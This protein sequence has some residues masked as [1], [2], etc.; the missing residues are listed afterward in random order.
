[1]RKLFVII[2]LA[3]MLFTSHKAYALFDDAYGRNYPS[4]SSHYSSYSPLDLSYEFRDGLSVELLGC[5]VND[6]DG[7]VYNLFLAKS[8]KDMKLDVAASAL[9]DNK[10]GRFTL[11]AVTGGNNWGIRMAGYRT[12]NLTLIADVPIIIL[13][14]YSAEYEESSRKPENLRTASTM[15]YLFNGQELEFNNIRM[16]SW[17]SCLAKMKS[18]GYTK[19]E[20]WERH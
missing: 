10:G 15:T 4:S 17:A 16:Q 9:F 5:Y 13:F 20:W 19:Q 11:G 6:E 8:P 12:H 3:A 2:L 14:A 7:N 18:L 1:M